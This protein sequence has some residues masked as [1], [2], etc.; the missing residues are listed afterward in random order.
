MTRILREM[1]RG[2]VSPEIAN[3]SDRLQ[4][5]VGRGN[6]NP[7]DLDLCMEST[8]EAWRAQRQRDEGQVQSMF[9]H[10]DAKL[11]GIHTAEDMHTILR[12]VW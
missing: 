11:G 8:M 5:A 7:I 12:Q 4:T 10:A 1:F 2:I 9:R 3:L 6:T